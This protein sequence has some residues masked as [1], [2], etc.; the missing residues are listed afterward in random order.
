MK[1]LISIL[2]CVAMVLSLAA[3]TFAT[4]DDVEIVLGDN[5]VTIPQ[6][7]TDAECYR[8]ITF[9]PDEAGTYVITN[10]NASGSYKY[11]YIAPYTWAEGG[12]NYGESKEVELEA[13]VP[14]EFAVFSWDA[15]EGEVEVAFNISKKEATDEE[16]DDP[17]AGLE[18][19]DY[20]QEGENCI[21]MLKDEASWGNITVTFVA[22]RDGYYV[23]E[24][25]DVGSV[26]I[27]GW[28]IS[29]PEG[30]ILEEGQSFEFQL[31]NYDVYSQNTYCT[32]TITW[33]EPPVTNDELQMGDNLITW[34]SS[35]DKIKTLE[36][37]IEETGVYTITNNMGSWHYLT[38]ND[39]NRIYSGDSGRVYLQEG[40]TLSIEIENDSKA[41]FALTI[42]CVPGEPVPDG[43]MEFPFELEEGE[44]FQDWADGDDFYYTFT[45]PADGVLTIEGNLNDCSKSVS[46]GTLIMVEAG[47]YSMNLT[48]GTE[49]T[50]NLYYGK[51]E[52]PLLLN[53]S[54]EEGELQANGT[55]DYPF[56]LEL[57]EYNKTFTK[58]S[59]YYTFTATEDGF[60]RIT[61]S[62]DPASSE[63]SNAMFT[64][65][66][67][68]N[69]NGTAYKY[70]F[71]GETVTIAIGS[72]GQ[73]E[74]AYT[75]SFE[76]AEYVPDGS[77]SEPFI[78]QLG[79]TNITLTESQAYTG[80][81]YKFVAP[82]DG[83]VKF[84]LPAGAYFYAEPD[85]MTV[86]DVDGVK[87]GTMTMTADQTI[88]FNIFG[89]SNTALNGNIAVYYEG[90]DIV[91]P[92]D[93]TD[94]ENPVD[95]ENPTKPDDDGDFTF[96][97]FAMIVLSMT[98]MVVLV[99]KK[100]S[101]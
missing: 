54:F 40:E 71:A 24:P 98:G 18:F 101:F 29:G 53:V 59:F 87:V 95:P 58:N 92:E 67:K 78:L 84:V 65:M 97:F 56:A 22:E 72:Y 41:P 6:A 75:I 99:S 51:P 5:V 27:N 36:M 21:L 11:V 28:A 13:G 80:F 32:F 94:P 83:V 69:T 15:A 23:F 76:P 82:K 44:M 4:E 20:P 96:V 7:T 1:K 79:Y 39:D 19:N 70:V 62:L 42:S 9:T 12:I 46:G 26:K 77:S 91:E 38:I 17:L 60:L 49:V 88:K 100:R 35:D 73:L 37:V 25:G 30:V 61:T 57:G 81:Y 93:P 2:L 43:S 3:V 45:A 8:Y 31:Y 52:K 34:S 86:E 50:I 66:K 85:A 47:V 10:T 90:E 48:E 16:P 68:D 74:A 33:S 14:Y 64:G 89:D 55:E 63:F